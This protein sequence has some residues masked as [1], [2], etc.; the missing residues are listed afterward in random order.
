[1]SKEDKVTNTHDLY[2]DLRK[3]REKVQDV[4]GGTE[5]LRAK[6]QKYLPP[7]PEELPQSY[8]NRLK[9]TTLHNVYAKT[10]TVMT[11]LVFT[12][13]I[14]LQDDVDEQI[15]A[16]AESIDNE[17]NHLNVFSREAF[18]LSF[19][20]AAVI[21]VDSPDTP[22]SNFAEQ[23]RL[24]VR[25]Y[26]SLYS[27]DN[28]INWRYAVNPLTKQKE[29]TLIV[30]REITVEPV[31]KFGNEEVVRYR[32]Y[33][34][35]DAGVQLEVYKEIEVQEG[36]DIILEQPA[37]YLPVT[38]IPVGVVGNLEAAP[39]LLDL[40]NLNIKHYQKES[41]FDN[42]EVLA[43]VPLFYTKGLEMEDDAQ[44]MIV[45]AD[46]HYRLSSDG[47]VGW[48][49]IDGSG[50]DSL[51]QSLKTL[52]EEMA[53]LG[54]SMLAGETA[55]V[56]MTATEAIFEN[57]AETAQLRVM[58]VQLQ[59]TIE[60]CLGHTAEFLGLERTRGGSVRIGAIWN[61]D[62]S[63]SSNLDEMNTKAD[64]ANKLMG[65]MPTEWIVKFL[66]VSDENEMREII[67]QI[68]A[69]DAIVVEPEQEMPLD[70]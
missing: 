70:E 27:A 30:L 18:D 60:L 23:T 50:F 35:D 66:G 54:L 45:G 43:A 58:G 61:T 19:E 31:G 62:S 16:L 6:A 46:V 38:Q 57:I 48:S 44:P 14:S 29:L 67:E 5:N 24:G 7:F 25:P 1:M 36:K 42:L 69:S 2:D 52:E 15:V 4:R 65:I 17:G 33:F 12:D 63:F 68:R 8:L 39:P 41:N 13:A 53:K 28:V 59:D 20:G 51:R 56:D 40:A 21:V 49:Q 55:R 26:W 3:Q 32:A 64:I 34:K 22:T 11:G 37:I 10:V 9:T 47:E